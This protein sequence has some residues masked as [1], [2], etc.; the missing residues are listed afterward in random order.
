[1]LNVRSEEE[2]VK[3]FNNLRFI[4]GLAGV[5]KEKIFENLRQKLIIEQSI[6]GVGSGV[7]GGAN[8]AFNS[9]I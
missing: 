5:I 4:D 2:Y 8:L 1:M 9:S 3:K 6:Y 7:L